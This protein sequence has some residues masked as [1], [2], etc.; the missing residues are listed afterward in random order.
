MRTETLSSL[1][2]VQQLLINF[3]VDKPRVLKREYS[4]TL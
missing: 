2:L 3:S 1:H 4:S